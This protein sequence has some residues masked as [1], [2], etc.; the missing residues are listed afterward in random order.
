MQQLKRIEEA[1]DQVE[2]SEV[3]EQT[4]QP[5]R[6]RDIKRQ[7]KEA[8]FD[9]KSSALLELQVIGSEDEASAQVENTE[10]KVGEAT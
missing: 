3:A 1:L 10:N 4:S 6:K 7:E 9:S 8:K 2:T 5:E